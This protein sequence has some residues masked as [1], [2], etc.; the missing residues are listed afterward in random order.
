MYNASCIN[1]YRERAPCSARRCA[2]LRARRQTFHLVGR[3]GEVS[4]TDSEL[5][6]LHLLSVIYM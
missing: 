4:C 6:K 2:V 3:K 5:R 1:T